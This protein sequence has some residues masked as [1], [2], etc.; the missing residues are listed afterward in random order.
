MVHP[1]LYHGAGYHANAR[2]LLD[3]T[4]HWRP[5]INGYSSFAPNSFFARAARLQA[6]PSPAAIAELRAIR[7]SHV[8]LHRAPLEAS[9]GAAVVNGL[10]AHPD[11]EFILEQDGVIVYRLR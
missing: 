3:Q 9:L 1:P 10:R 7:V 2:Y 4:R 11:L 8:V 6:F 5:M